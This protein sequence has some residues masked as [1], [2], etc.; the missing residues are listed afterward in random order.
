LLRLL[1]ICRLRLMAFALREM[2]AG[3]ER[4]ESER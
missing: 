3:K 1:V 2:I 4:K